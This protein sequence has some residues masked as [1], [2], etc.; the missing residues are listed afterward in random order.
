MERWE[1]FF[2]REMLYK[3]FGNKSRFSNYTANNLVMIVKNL[4]KMKYLISSTNI[5]K[6]LA[7]ENF[8][9]NL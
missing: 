9:L 6:K 7:I 3:I 1:R 2:R 8:L 5:N 4:E